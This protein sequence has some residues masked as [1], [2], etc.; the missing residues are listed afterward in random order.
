[1]ETAASFFSIKVA[2][3]PKP[4]PSKI[5]DPP[6]FNSTLRKSNPNILPITPSSRRKREEDC[7]N[8]AETPSKKVME[9]LRNE[10]RKEE[11][12]RCREEI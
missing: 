12:G 3:G 8:E 4:A 10:D 7:I 11:D 6:G 2:G 9:D 1:M 5:P